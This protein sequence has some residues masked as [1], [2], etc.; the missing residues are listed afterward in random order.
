MPYEPW[1][2][3]LS[4]GG[5]SGD[6]FAVVFGAPWSNLNLLV[7]AFP[8]TLKKLSFQKGPGACKK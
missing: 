8:K 3:R 4:G 5:G 7:V 1:E 6:D 2:L